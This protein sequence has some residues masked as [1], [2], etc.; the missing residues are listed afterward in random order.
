MTHCYDISRFVGSWISCSGHRL[1]IRKV[2]E[3]AASVDFLEPSG[4]PVGRL[5]MEGVLSVGMVA[6]YQDYEGSFEVEL[7]EPGKGFILHLEHEYDYELD[8]Q[9]REALVPALSR[10]EQDHF[11]D[12]F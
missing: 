2:S 12:E 7:W 8:H 10:Y 6:R 1:V 5:Y 9:R 3:D 4:M 11:L